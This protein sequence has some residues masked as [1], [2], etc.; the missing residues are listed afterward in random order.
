MHPGIVILTEQRRVREQENVFRAVLRHMT[1]R[2][3][4]NLAIEATA[5]AG[6]VH[7]VAYELHRAA[8]SRDRPR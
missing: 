8:H 6:E 2:D 3:A 5:I 7:I 4:M 1:G